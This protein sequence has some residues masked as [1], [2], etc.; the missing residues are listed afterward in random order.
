MRPFAIEPASDAAVAVMAAAKGGGDVQYLAGGTTLIDL[1]KLDVL[2]PERLIDI[3]PLAR[4]HGAIVAGPGGLRLGALVRMSDAAVHPAVRA[5]WPVIAQTLEAA[6]SPQIRNMASLGGNV[7]QRTRCAYYRDTR[8]AACNKRTPGSGCA[9]L[10]GVNRRHAVLGVSEAC[11]AAYPGDFAQALIALEA[12]VVTLAPGGGRRIAFEDLHRPPGSTPHLETNL[13]PG[14][15]IVAFE[16]PRAPW[17]ARSLYV[18]IRDR[19]S[20]DFALASAAVALDMDGARVREAR[21][22]LGGVA[23]R[24][25]RAR[26]AEGALR[27]TVLDEASAAGAARAAFAGARAHG[28]AAFKRELGQRTLVRALLA[29]GAMEV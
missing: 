20:Y 15:L 28:E 7:L 21:I 18:K 29:A 3:N 23:S 25:W 4:E 5:G 8:W 14:E 11:I 2:A 26:Q 22:A 6:A 27:G 24:P 17:A 9:A 1:M 19:A 13:A 10:E 16:I 12:V